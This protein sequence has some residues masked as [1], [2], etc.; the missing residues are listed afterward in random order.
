MYKLGDKILE[1]CGNKAKYLSL[2]K[3]K[4]YNIPFGIV[5][6]FEEFKNMISNQ[7][8]NFETIDKVEIPDE[9]IKENMEYK[10]DRQFLKFC[11]KEKNMQ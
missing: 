6:D 1:N 2:L 10:I 5:I 8:L 3:S 11:Q 4:G 7:K 9:L